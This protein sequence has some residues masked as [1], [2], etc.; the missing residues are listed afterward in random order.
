[1]LNLKFYYLSY[2]IY[3][4]INNLEK[5]LRWLSFVLLPSQ[6]LGEINLNYITAKRHPVRSLELMKA[7]I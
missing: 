1:V 3:T 6:F 4:A 7:I 5:M 2:T